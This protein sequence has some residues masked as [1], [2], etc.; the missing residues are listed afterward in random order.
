MAAA[1]IQN[2]EA[3][4][5]LADHGD[6]LYRYARSRVTRDE[7]AED[8]VQETFLAALRNRSSFR[9]ESTFRTWLIAI[10]R[11]KILDLHR[12]HAHLPSA[13]TADPQT[14]R[15]QTF[16]PSGVWKHRIEPWSVAN[17]PVESAEFRSALEHCLARLPKTLSSLFLLREVEAMS[18]ADLA[19]DLEI[20]EPNVRV[21]LHR[22]RLLL[23]NCLAKSWFGDETENPLRVS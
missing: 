10:L 8:L 18:T 15:E 4:G 19:R 9:G 2:A 23:R 6:A 21:R 22:A 17:D 11:M 13:P 1:T 3:E 12:R 14:I 5:W 20:S 7:E 16:Q